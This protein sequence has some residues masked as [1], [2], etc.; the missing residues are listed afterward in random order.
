MRNCDIIIPIYNAYDCLKPCIDSVLENTD[1]NNNRL[2]LINDQSTDERVLPLLKEYSNNP[3]IVLL[4]NEKNLG[5]VA[6]VNKGMQYSSDNDV[7]LLNSDTEVTKN[8]LK[9]IQKCAY[10]RDDIATVTPLSNNATLVSVPKS[11]FPNNL[12]DGYDLDSFADV[13]EKASFKDYP[14]V[15]TGQGFCLFIKREALNIV[16]FFDEE[17]YG[18]GYGE[19]NDFCFRCLDVGL[20]HVVCDEAYVYHKESQSFSSARSK[21][22]AQALKVLDRKYPLY[23]NKLNNWIINKSIDYLG[24]NINLE[25]GKKYNNNPNILFIIHEWGDGPDTLGGTTLHAWDIIKKLVKYYNFHIL[26]YEDNVYKVYS[27][28]GNVNNKT[29]IHY[30]SIYSF[31]QNNFYNKRYALMLQEIIEKFNINCVHIHHLK[32]HYFDAID[33]SQKNKLKVILTIHDF[34]FVCPTIHMIYLDKY[35][36][37]SPSVDKCSLCLNSRYTTVDRSLNFVNRWRTICHKE[38]KKCDLLITPSNTTKNEMLKFYND[39]EIE[40]IEHGIDIYKF[41]KS[42]NNN[43]KHFNTAF[44]GVIGIH[45]GSDIL[46][47]LSKRLYFSNIK[48]H[49]FGILPKRLRQNK[50]YINHGQYKREELTKLLHENNI[51]LVC[52]FSIWPETYS[53]TL[54]EV[55][56]CGIPVLAFDIGAIAERIKKY[57]L[58]YLLPINSDVRT[59]KKEIIRISKNRQEYLEKINSIKN[60]KIKSVDEMDQEYSEIYQKHFTN[61]DLKPEYIY[62]KNKIKELSN[63][64]ANFNIQ[65]YEQILNSLKW[66]VVSKIKIPKSISKIYR[67][68]RYKK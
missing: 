34:F 8:W 29:E 42:F 45:K 5:F 37:D 32:G 48:L 51:D 47:N 7:L 56:S 67:Q 60:Y 40:V 21:L 57:N 27:Y 11:F 9:K 15:P 43:Q 36:C 6:S 49:L 20:T 62:I 17:T 25:L 64:H 10:S 53:Y 12:P 28:W 55:I 52:L 3:S 38:L 33:V 65:Y 63:E 23:Q 13:V 24:N 68:I 44:I 58:G 66:K 16:G 19:E 50:H 61:L 30:N 41:E 39:L 54:T 31:S 59:I 26:V 14:E 2:I 4:E 22:C 46:V 18:K 1:M 35:H